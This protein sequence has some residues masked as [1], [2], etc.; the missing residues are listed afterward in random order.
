MSRTPVIAADECFVLFDQVPA[1]MVLV[2]EGYQPC[3]AVA[4]TVYANLA[5]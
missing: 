2:I 3:V 5:L 1:L 4:R